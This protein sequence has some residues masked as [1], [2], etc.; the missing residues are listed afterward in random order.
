[1]PRNLYASIAAAVPRDP[2]VKMVRRHP[3]FGVL[4]AVVFVQT[5]G[6]WRV[7]PSQ[8]SPLRRGSTADVADAA[9]VVSLGRWENIGCRIKFG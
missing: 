2:W 7:W 8:K 1:M 5:H 9:D 4:F 6:V 3:L